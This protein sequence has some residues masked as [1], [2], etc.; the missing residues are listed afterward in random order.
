MAPTRPN[1]G[2]EAQQSEVP[3]APPDSVA[4]QLRALNSELNHLVHR[5]AREAGLHTTDLRALVAVLEAPTPLTPGRLGMHLGS[6]SGAVTACLDRLEKAG[7]LRRVRA[8]TDR[9]VVHLFCEPPGRELAAGYLLFLDRAA[10][11]AVERT[12]GQDTA[13]ALRFLELLRREMSSTGAD[14]PDRPA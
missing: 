3:A 11:K 12:G 14:P 6:G 9:R 13:T 1:D 8:A 7:H 4:R 5:F 10:R 2:P